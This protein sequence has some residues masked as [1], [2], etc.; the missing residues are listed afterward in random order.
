MIVVLFMAYIGFSGLISSQLLHLQHAAKYAEV[1]TTNGTSLQVG[2]F[3]FLSFCPAGLL[4]S[5]VL[6][7]RAEGGTLLGR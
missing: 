6:E 7:A 5:I 3:L 4:L 1:L 2:F